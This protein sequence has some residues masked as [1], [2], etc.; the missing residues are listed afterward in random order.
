MPLSLR[1]S[2]VLAVAA[3]TGIV[4]VP[5]VSTAQAAPADIYVNN[6][7]GTCSD[8]G[9]GT[10]AQPFCTISAA[11][12][13]VRPGQTVRVVGITTYDEAVHLTRSGTPEQPI[14]FL[15]T[16]LT[17]SGAAEQPTLYPKPAQG[18]ALTLDGVHDVVFR[19]F[20]FYSQDSTAANPSV[21]VKNSSRVTIDGS[22]FPDGRLAVTGGSDGVTISRNTF[23]D[24]GG[25]DLGAGT[26][27]AL[28]TANLLSDTT[29]AAVK[30]VDAPGT[31][32]TNN[33]ILLSCEES[34]R[35]DGASPDAVIENNVITAGYTQ[36]SGTPV[37]CST[38]GS[39]RGETEISVSAASTAGTVVD[40]N[41]V[42]PWPDANAY[43]WSGTPYPTVAAF[44][45]TG[46]GAHDIDVDVSCINGNCNIPSSRLPVLLPVLADSADPDAPGVGTDLR[47]YTY[48]DHPNAADNPGIRDRGA[49]EATGQRGVTLAVTSGQSGTKLTA[50]LTV[51]A[52]ATVQ[53]DWPIE[54]ADY[55][56]TFGDGT[57]V[58]STSPTVTHTYLTAGTFQPSLTIVDKHGAKASASGSSFQVATTQ[59]AADPAIEVDPGLYATILPHVTTPWYLSSEEID[60]GDGTPKESSTYGSS[61]YYHQYMVAGDYQLTLTDSDDSGRTLVTKRTVHVASARDT[62][63]LQPGRRVQL[64]IR[65]SKDWLG[66]AGANYDAG[67]WGGFMPVPGAG[68]PAKQVTSLASV[69]TADQYL[70]AFA[71]ANGKLYSADRNLGPAAG[72]VAQGQWLPWTEVTR[73]NGAGALSGISQ[74]S[75]ASTGNRIHV[76]AVANGRVY[77][78]Y[79]DRAAGTWTKWADVTGALGFP[80]NATS[81]S[82]AFIGNVL[83]VAMVCSDGHVRIGDGDYNRGRWSGGDLTGSIGYAWPSQYTKPVQVGVAATPDGKLHVFAVVWDRLLEATGDYTA[84]RWSNWGD[85]SAATGMNKVGQVTVAGNGSTLRVFTLDSDGPGNIIEVDGD[86][87]AG[88]WTRAAPVNGIGPAGGDSSTSLFAAAGL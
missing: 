47:G 74:V 55:A 73:A 2:A 5:A 76:L 46:R 81:A 26:Q 56:F 30:A 86:Y 28:V 17:D 36:R 4:T 52:T 33:T 42:H 29:S 37:G 82:A 16:P 63:A 62:A 45:A 23:V 31:A 22:L 59:L 70:R 51:T 67:V 78:S 14:V 38:A 39:T 72:G 61:A 53:S 21:V 24:H 50:P 54:Q 60:F 1:Q 41:S 85:V 66:D 15:G 49:Y 6:W 10:A 87:V 57:T 48:A 79:G 35:L 65:N 18:S 43:T 25:I 71:L 32:I 19:G 75:A 68:F 77:E 84:G 13:V 83:H 58:H 27:H 80:A 7:G 64:L 40:Y 3:A 12:A 44:Q 88:R 9:G 20:G 34:V 8:T 69:T 11:A